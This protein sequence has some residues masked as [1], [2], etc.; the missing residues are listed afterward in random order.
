MKKYILRI[1]DND[2]TFSIIE[3]GKSIKYKYQSSIEKDI[4]VL[5]SV[6]DLIYGF[7]ST[8]RKVNY[9]FCVERIEGTDTIIMKK[10][11]EDYEGASISPEYERLVIQEGLV[12][13]QEDNTI[14]FDNVPTL[15]DIVVDTD[16][17]KEL[18]LSELGKILEKTYQNGSN[19]NAAILS[20]CI[21]YGNVINKNEY[22]PKSIVEQT[23]LSESYHAE[24]L[25]GLNLYLSILKNEYGIKFYKQPVEE[26]LPRRNK[27]TNRVNPFNSIIYGAPG[28]GKTYAIPE[29]VINILDGEKFDF[30]AKTSA[31]RKE[32]LDK[33]NSYIKDGRVVFTTF[34]QNYGYEDFIQGLRPETSS[35]SLSFKNVD[36]VF[37]KIANRAIQDNENDYVIIIDEIN[38]A[39]ISKVFGELITLIEEDKRWGED[40]ELSVVLP[41][42]E[43]FAVPN[44]LYIIGTMNSS[45][46]SISLIDAALRRRFVF[47]EQKPNEK[48]IEDALLQ[49]IFI[50]LNKTLV[51][52][53]DGTDLLIGHSYFIGKTED[54]LEDIMNH[55]V[56]PLLYEYFYDNR[57]KVSTVLADILKTTNLDILDEE[58]GRLSVKKRNE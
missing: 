6:N 3:A 56:I 2:N 33:Y 41:S 42:G 51:S 21:K 27:N 9:I 13:Y 54:D 53:L 19:K 55:K 8:K 5:M 25:K 43:K 15:E 10:L 47:I 18:S 23:S 36:G 17:P 35:M 30:S 12:E 14:E 38:R 45:D 7:S 11:H 48:L 16:F 37:K 50:N 49:S 46:K 29:L 26:E 24:V 1:E 32:V 34:H 39:N 44:N 40:N 58:F 31:E 28:T 20:F 22:T 57:K 4:F 52:E